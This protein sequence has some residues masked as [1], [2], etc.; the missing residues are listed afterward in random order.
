MS[1]SCRML[2]LHSRSDSLVPVDSVI[3][4]IDHTTSMTGTT[5]GHGK[6]EP[7]AIHHGCVGNDICIT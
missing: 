5:L 4:A 7:E 1:D 6:D 3:R 2:L